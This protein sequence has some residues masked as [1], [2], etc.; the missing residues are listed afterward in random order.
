MTLW[1][2]MFEPVTIEAMISLGFVH[3][4]ERVAREEIAESTLRV[5]TLVLPCGS[6]EVESGEIVK[7]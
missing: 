6:V 7:A 2:F 4:K 1:L 5:K 3:A